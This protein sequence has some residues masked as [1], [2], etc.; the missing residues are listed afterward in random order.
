MPDKQL[1]FGE[2][3]RNALQR[4]VD[5][6]SDAVKVTLGPMGRNVVIHDPYRGPTVTKVGV[7]VA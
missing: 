2:A 5:I 7:T 4:G 1:I 3:A 6:V